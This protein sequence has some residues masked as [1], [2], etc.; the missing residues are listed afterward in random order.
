MADNQKAIEL[1]SAIAT[2]Y[3]QY[4]TWN[5]NSAFY[6]LA[7]TYLFQFYNNNVRVWDEWNNGWV[8]NFHSI[9]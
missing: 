3:N 6:I 5:N 2:C 8:G 7:P 1:N 9:K 4:F